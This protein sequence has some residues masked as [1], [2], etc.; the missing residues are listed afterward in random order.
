M[1]ADNLL[2]PLPDASAAETF[3]PLLDRPGAR[4][5]RIVSAGQTTPED[6]PYDQPHDEWVL[7]L[8]GGARLWLED[9][10]ET[11]LVPGDALLIPANVKHRVTWT[12]AE[13]PTVWL[14]VHFSEA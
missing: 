6:A 14:A 12:Q 13:P 4:I 8:A 10:G 5:E 9:K 7:L 11:A 3:T 1:A 2:S